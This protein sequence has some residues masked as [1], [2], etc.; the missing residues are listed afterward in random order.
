MT[1]GLTIF[2]L[3]HVVISLIGILSGFVVA[4]GFL[5]ARRLDGWTATFLAS[6][7]LTSVTG[8]LFPFHHFLPSHGVGIISLVILAMAIFARY[9]RKLA[10]A[11]RTTYV[12]AAMVAL[13]LNVFVLVV[14]LFQK[15]PV[16]K[17]MAPTQSEPPFV[18]A[19]IAVLALFV[20]LSVF[21]AIR[22]RREQLHA[23]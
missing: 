18:V 17:A 21:A 13:Y 12:V 7:V 6:T 15:V 9:S 1:L 10:G 22:F 4:Y 20:M 16:L 3:V 8:F 23:A 11:W 19:Q 14:Q 2:T 5:A